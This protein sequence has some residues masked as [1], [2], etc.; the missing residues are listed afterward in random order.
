MKCENSV[1]S[2]NSRKLDPLISYKRFVLDDLP[3]P[4]L[5]STVLVLISFFYPSCGL[6]IRSSHHFQQKW[7][8]SSWKFSVITAEWCTSPL[9][10]CPSLSLCEMRTTWVGNLLPSNN[11]SLVGPSVV[12]NKF[13]PHNGTFFL[14]FWHASSQKCGNKRP[15]PLTLFLSVLCLIMPLITWHHI[16]FHLFQLSSHTNCMTEIRNLIC[17]ELC[18]SL[19]QH[20]MVF[21]YLTILCISDSTCCQ[22]YS[23]ANAL[24]ISS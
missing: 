16:G 2:E 14:K 7:D 4:C 18:L 17:F 24:M 20:C 11:N 1:Y 15:L 8:L 22:L 9:K 3:V 12:H 21:S 10:Y 23:S 19:P 13:F 6:I 5:W